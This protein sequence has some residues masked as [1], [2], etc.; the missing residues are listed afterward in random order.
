MRIGI[1]NVPD[2]TDAHHVV[3]R[4]TFRVP[5]HWDHGRVFLFARSDV[6][7]KWRRYLDGKP[8]EVQTPRR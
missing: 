6:R 7:G 8:L 2:N 5:E 1:Y 3:F 4:K